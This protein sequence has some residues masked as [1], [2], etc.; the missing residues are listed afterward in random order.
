MRNRS[1]SNESN[2]YK[3][4]ADSI[5]S[6][7]PTVSAQ[8]STA[9]EPSHVQYIVVGELRNVPT[10]LNSELDRRESNTLSTQNPNHSFSVH[11]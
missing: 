3:R 7:T 9:W 1:P 8:V 6:A 2:H 11:N 4:N 5:N 10:P